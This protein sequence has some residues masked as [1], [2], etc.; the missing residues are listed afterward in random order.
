MSAER[1]AE[2]LAHRVAG[3][4]SGAWLLQLALGA[5]DQHHRVTRRILDGRA[6][7]ADDEAASFSHLGANR[8]KIRVR[9]NQLLES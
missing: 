6:H 2:A 4:S 9:A 8:L 5:L 7:F 3:L 1:V